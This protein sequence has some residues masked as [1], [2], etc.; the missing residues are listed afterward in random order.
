MKFL[1]KKYWLL[2]VFA[3]VINIPI[4]IVGVTTTNQ[5]IVLKGDT[6]PFTS[7]VEVDTDYE[8]KGSFSTIY[9]VA[10]YKSTILQNFFSDLTPT[11]ERYTISEYSSHITNEE[12]YLGSKIDYN[13][14][15]QK[16]IILAYSEAKK[17]DPTISIEYRLKSYDV[18]YYAKDSL[19][20]IGDSIIGING[21]SIEKEK[22]FKE[23]WKK[24]RLVGDT[25]DVIVKETGITTQYV[26]ESGY[27][28]FSASDIYDIN[29]SSI[30][31]SVTINQTNVG[32]PSGGLLQTLSIYNRLVKEDLTHGFKIAG[33]GTISYDGTV[34]AIGGI[35]EKIPTALDDGIDIF[36]C[37]SANYKDAKEA[38][39]S[40]PNRS[41][42]RLVEIKTFYD[43]LNYLLEG[44]K[45]DF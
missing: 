19:F 15:I 5:E 12:N 35:R 17:S 45:N 38:Y 4:F 27:T 13:S 34:G 21:I 23:E 16:A 40:L 39:N 9:V 28:G 7:V 1:I 10:M 43:A 25:F 42:M 6:V 14:S 36:F 3:I 11:T 8:E 31:P 32:G 44:Y 41:S 18:T 29:M 37:A 2:L 26:L 33:T 24:Q 22:E 20:R 30:F